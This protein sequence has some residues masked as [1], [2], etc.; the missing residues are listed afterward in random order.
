MEITARQA[1]TVFTAHGSAKA[2]GKITSVFADST[3]RVD[4]GLILEIQQWPH[5]QAAGRGVGV[6]GDTGHVFLFSAEV[7]N[8]LQI[9]GQLL[10]RHGDV[11]DT[12]HRLIV[13][14]TPHQNV[15]PALRTSQ[16]SFWR[17]GFNNL[18]TVF[19]QPRVC[20]WCSRASSLADSSRSSVP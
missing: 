9:V 13:S 8:L 10:L 12:W 19:R 20:R 2:D 18:T 16:T 4:A 1:I 14:T 5:M 6:D 15:Q 7:K 17:A 3:Q 11:F